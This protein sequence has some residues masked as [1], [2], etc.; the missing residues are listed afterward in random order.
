[1]ENHFFMAG[2]DSQHADDSINFTVSTDETYKGKSIEEVQAIHLAEAQRLEV[3]LKKVLPGG[4][5]DRLMAI[6]MMKRGSDFI[7][8][9]HIP[10][11]QKQK[12]EI[13]Y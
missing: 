11:D 4:V 5:Y 2:V 8:P 12:I 3:V 1:M 6:M 10:S 7:I 9:L 13:T